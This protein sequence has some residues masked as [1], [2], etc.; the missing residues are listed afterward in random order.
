MKIHEF[1]QQLEFLAK[2]LRSLPNTELDRTFN[3]PKNLAENKKGGRTIASK[4]THD[5]LPEGIV[6]RLR[7]MS[8]IEIESFLT[9]KTEPFTSDQ[10]IMLAEK[11]KIPT[12]KRQ[13]R[14]ALLNQILRYF[15]AGQ[16]DSIIR[17]TRED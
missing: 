17:S 9:A 8:P 6:D 14:V 4:V 1:A 13:S 12:S 15:E 11:L 10:L 16:M 7:N 2:L 5:L 3:K